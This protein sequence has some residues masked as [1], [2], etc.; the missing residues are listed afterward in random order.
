MAHGTWWSTNR[1]RLLRLSEVPADADG[2]IRRAAFVVPRGT[3]LSDAAFSLA[4]V[5]RVKGMDQMALEHAVSEP[6]T[7][8]RLPRWQPTGTWESTGDPALVFRPGELFRVTFTG[9]ARSFLTIPSRVVAALAD[10]DAAIAPD[11]PFRAQPP[12]CQI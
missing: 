12:A 5:A 4:V 6:G 9:P 3:G 7:A 10:S 8:W 11:N 2:V 1:H